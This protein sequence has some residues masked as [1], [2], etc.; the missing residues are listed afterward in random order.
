MALTLRLKKGVRMVDFVKRIRLVRAMAHQPSALSN[1]TTAVINE[2]G[3]LRS[4]GN[5]KRKSSAL[6]T[7]TIFVFSDFHFSYYTTVTAT[8]VSATLHRPLPP[9]PPLSLT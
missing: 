9:T 4:E 3:Y 6:L 5:M 7:S 2:N 1:S 8:L